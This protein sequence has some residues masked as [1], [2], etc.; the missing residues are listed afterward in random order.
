MHNQTPR[1]TNKLQIVCYS[2][3]TDENYHS[4]FKRTCRQKSV[5]GVLKRIRNFESVR[6]T[7]EKYPSIFLKERVDEKS[8]LEVFKRTRKFENVVEENTRPYFYQ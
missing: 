6:R 8:I 7:E 1:Y 2:H 5:L 3:R 4:I